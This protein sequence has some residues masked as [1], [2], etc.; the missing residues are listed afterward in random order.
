LAEEVQLAILLVGLKTRTDLY[1]FF[2]AGQHLCSISA[3]PVE[4][5]GFYKRFDDLFVDGS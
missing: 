3:E 4:G 2:D 5:T 1:C